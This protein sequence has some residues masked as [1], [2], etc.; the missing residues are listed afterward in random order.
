MA[1]IVVRA[2]ARLDVDG[3]FA[4]IAADNLDAAIRVDDA[5][6]AAFQVLAENPKA[7]ALCEFTEADLADLRYWPVKKYRNYLVIYRP[8]ASGVEVVRVVHAATDLLRAVRGT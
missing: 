3:I 8:L 1:T 4:Y 2:R 7:G 5:I 6:T